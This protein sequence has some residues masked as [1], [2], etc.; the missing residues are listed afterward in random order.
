[1]ALLMVAQLGGGLRPNPALN[2]L[3]RSVRK[4]LPSLPPA[5]AP[6]SDQ[7][8]VPDR[9]FPTPVGG[10]TF[11][12]GHWERQINGQEYYAPSLPACTSAG[13]CVTTPAGVRPQ[14]PETR[15]SP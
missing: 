14:A 7:V 3:D 8:W 6:R 4:P 13:Q 5:P 2:Q 12:P 9:Y 10:T 15:Q 1:M 11:V